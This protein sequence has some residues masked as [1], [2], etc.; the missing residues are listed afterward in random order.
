MTLAPE[1]VSV[2]VVDDGED[3]ADLPA[4]LLEEYGHR[5]RVAYGGA[6]ALALLEQELPAL[7]APDLERHAVFVR[8]V[9]QGVGFRP[10]VHRLATCLELAGWVRNRAGGVV[11]EV[12]GT[13]ERLTS[14]VERLRRECPPLARLEEIDIAPRRPTGDRTFRIEHSDASGRTD[15][16][17][18][19]PDVA[20]CEDCLR[21][22]FDSS[23][24]RYRYPFINCTHCGPRLTIIRTAPYDRERTTMAAFAMCDACRAEYEDP[25]DRRFHAQPIACP[26]CGPRLAFCDAEGRAIDVEPLSA[27]RELLVSG[28]IVA[29]KGLGGYHL[30]CDAS[31]DVAVRTLRERKHRDEKPFAV[32]VPDLESARRLCHVSEAEAE[33]LSSR[34]RPIVLLQRR[35]DAPIARSV[36]PN[37]P[38]VGMMLP[39]TPL[40]HL[41]VRE[42]AGPIV[43]T[44]GN[45]SDEPIAFD[46]RDAVERLHCIAD[47]YLTHD[48]P[49]HLRCDDSVARV[50]AGR[51]SVLRRSRGHAPE[52]IRLSLAFPRRVLALG[53]HLKNTFALGR[54]VH[55]V[56][57][58]HLGDLGDYT[59]YR[60]FREAV[61]HY[62]CLFAFKPEVL[63]HDLHPGYATTEYAR[64][65][66]SRAPGLRLLP[67][68]H[69][70]AHMA[71]CM[72]ENGLAGPVIAVAFDGTGYGTDGSLWGGEFLVGDY[73]TFRRAAHLRAVPLPGGEH[74]IRE[75]WRMA[76]AHLVD[77][78]E[79]AQRF[80]ASAP[81][82]AIRIVLRMIEKRIN[83]PLTTSAG[84]LFDAVSALLGVRTRVSFEGQ[85]AMELEWLATT[86]DASDSLRGVWA[87][88]DDDVVDTRPIIRAI[89]GAVSR[90][91]SPAD[92]ARRF[93]NT[94]AEIIVGV[95]SRVRGATG[96][97]DV[98]LT[99]GVFQNALLLHLA[100]T[101]LTSLG[102][103][104]HTHSRV[105]ANDGGL[106]LGQLAVAAATL[107]GGA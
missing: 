74:A 48:R 36:A 47:G 92:I 78:N 72:A 83:A 94:L 70:H 43:L 20:I 106:S 59:A 40:H 98:V 16:R 95:T 49:I 44:S 54:C 66:Q 27:C 28:Q 21:E 39:Y 2:V 80:I 104:V 75:P 96:I 13:G 55:A 12:E 107:E 53:G 23:N 7:P 84:R 14:F 26:A 67:V 29:V 68:Q 38:M 10:F 9:V 79:D 57:S 46:D 69:H 4:A 89:I 97:P 63:V 41:L 6:R 45:R 17:F 33:L 30:A 91:E 19:A 58:H 99:G 105:P 103:R 60:A 85:A 81:P 62:E 34:H 22:L 88:A 56:L 42:Y 1:T 100:R 82:E 8:G 101:R 18:F 32:M 52:P 5:V 77:C 24:R 61:A 25:R 35:L 11:I 93:H 76:V 86:S 50:M 90:G 64:E 37:N 3:N 31:K 102:L 15:E 65:R 71:S 87:S 73:R 51:A